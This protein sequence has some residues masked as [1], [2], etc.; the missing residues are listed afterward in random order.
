M[1]D[2]N[3]ATEESEMEYDVNFATLSSN[4][5]PISIITLI[6]I[7][8]RTQKTLYLSLQVKNPIINTPLHSVSN[9]NLAQNVS[10]KSFKNIQQS[11]KRSHTNS[12]KTQDEIPETSS[13][14]NNLIS[15]I[16]F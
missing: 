8:R 3:Q 4:W 12:H 7:T 10:F 13:D 5:W 9:G 2:A 14:Q 1:P 16:R 15:L 11:E 6:P